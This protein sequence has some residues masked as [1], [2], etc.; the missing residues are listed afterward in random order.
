ME[1]AGK[2]GLA[3]L[4][5]GGQLKG[6]RNVLN[7]IC[8]NRLCVNTNHLEVILQ[9]ENLSCDKRKPRKRNDAIIADNLEDFMAQIRNTDN[10]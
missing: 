4:P 2:H 1:G 9:S 7:H 10:D 5:L 6:E 8:H 3:A